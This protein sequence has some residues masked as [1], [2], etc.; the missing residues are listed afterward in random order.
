MIGRLIGRCRSFFRLIEALHQNFCPIGLIVPKG[1]DGDSDKSCTTD[2]SNCSLRQQQH[3]LWPK[4]PSS[5]PGKPP[6][7]VVGVA[8]ANDKL[9]VASPAQ[10]QLAIPANNISSHP[11][12]SRTR[13]SRTNSAE[14]PRC[15]VCPQ[16]APHQICA[17]VANM[18]D[19]QR[20]IRPAHYHLLGAGE[21]VP[22]RY[23]MRSYG[24]GQRG[25]STP[26]S[27]PPRDTRAP[28]L[29]QGTS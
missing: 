5:P 27:R 13:P 10:H 17:S 16:P 4:L 18:C 20:G 19:R 2:T 26:F 14:P 24:G 9:P 21:I 3:Q 8:G 25:R 29:G 1:R 22:S 11:T 7:R 23:V 12:T 15:R 28:N 6:Q